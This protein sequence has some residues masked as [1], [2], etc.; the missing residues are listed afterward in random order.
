MNFKD[1][2][3][4]NIGCNKM[5]PDRPFVIL[6]VQ[7]SGVRGKYIDTGFETEIKKVLLRGLPITPHRLRKLHFSLVNDS[8]IYDN[9]W[10][11]PGLNGFYHVEAGRAKTDIEFI[12]ELQNLYYRARKEELYLPFVKGILN[13]EAGVFK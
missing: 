9:I 10:L 6:S 2:R 7:S 5:E 11:R 12:H 13:I 4:G 8:Y 1:W 3:K